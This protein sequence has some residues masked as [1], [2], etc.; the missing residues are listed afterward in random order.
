MRRRR[1]AAFVDALLGNRRPR[2]FDPQS[3]D[4]DAMRAAI[5]LRA[6]QPGATLPSPEFVADLYR[7]L[8]E[9][10][11]EPRPEVT[12][13]VALPLTRRRALQGVTVAAAAAAIGVVVDRELISSSDTTTTTKASAKALEPDRGTWQPVAASADVTAGQVTPFSTA[14]TVGFVVND[15]GNLRAVSGVCTH[16]GC[17]LQHNQAD[18]RLD[19]PCHRAAFALDG[20]VLFHQFP[21]TLDPLPSVD[22]RDHDGNVE[23]FVP[24]PV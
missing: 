8:A 20:T 13:P 4:A 12:Q 17:L 18:G 24:P 9:E 2:H 14:T 6:A 5:E 3:D 7:R 21:G 15:G 22:V 11:D 23:V 19:C 10:F 16:Q 1:F